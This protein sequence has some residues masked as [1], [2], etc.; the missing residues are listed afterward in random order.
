MIGG[1]SEAGLE[2]DN[3]AA[4]PHDLVDMISLNKVI[5]RTRKGKTVSGFT[6]DVGIS[7]QVKIMTRQGKEEVF[8][9]GD[10][11]AIFFVKDFQGN[12]QYEEVKFLSQ[13]PPTEKLWV[14]AVFF[15][16]EVSEGAVKNNGELLNSQGFYLSPSDHDTNNEMVYIPKSALKELTILG[17]E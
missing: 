7:E 10:L 12:P 14:R 4:I 16:G 17:I 2:Y 11:K 5:I 1:N 8:I 9:L 15:D 13:Q 6:R 3:R